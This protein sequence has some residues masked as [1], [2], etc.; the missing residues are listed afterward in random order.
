M[1]IKLILLSVIL[2]SGALRAVE[3]HY[4][5][6]AADG[7]V[8]ESFDAVPD[9][10]PTAPAEGPGTS[11]A[12]KPITFEE[13]HSKL[14]YNVV[15]APS[16]PGEALAAIADS[17]SLGAKHPELLLNAV[18]EKV[19]DEV[20]SEYELRLELINK[21]RKFLSMLNYHGISADLSKEKLQEAI[22]KQNNRL[23]ELIGESAKA[24]KPAVKDAIQTKMNAVEMG[25][26]ESTSKNDML[27][28]KKA[29]MLSTKAIMYG[30]PLN[31][32]AGKIADY[33]KKLEH[34]IYNLVLDEKNGNPH[35]ECT[36]DSQRQT[37]TATNGDL[38]KRIAGTTDISRFV[39]KEGEAPASKVDSSLSTRAEQK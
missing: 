27:R 35:D 9:N 24:T 25:L 18:G 8:T 6:V 7:T 29:R 33:E 16:D 2:S 10:A 30:L 3:N 23:R 14:P 4:R 15:G 34:A 22:S 38:Y 20:S 13:T 12:A 21:K 26:S 28:I 37:C 5:T 39:N 11:L 32:S 31:S 36:F 17:P 1:H 19:I